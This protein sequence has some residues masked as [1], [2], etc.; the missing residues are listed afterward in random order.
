MTASYLFNPEELAVFTRYV[1]PDTLFAFDLDGTLAPIVDDYNAV[2][3]AEPVRDT[4]KR[5]AQL[6]KV[7]VITG[8]SRN[9]ALKILEFEPDLI[10]GNHGSEWPA[11]DGKRDWQQIALCVK[12]QEQLKNRLGDT[13][14]VEIEFKGESVSIHY[15][16][17]DDRE[18]AL[19]R[20]NDAIKIIEP[21]PR[22]IGGKFVVN[23][24]PKDATTKGDALVA[25]MDKFGL[26]RSVFLGDDVTDE[27]VFRLVGVDVLGI[28]IGKDYYTAA[29]YYLN[30]QS[31]L[32]GLLN[33]MVGTI[34]SLRAVAPPHNTNKHQS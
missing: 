10:I 30:D 6:A 22:R 3:I 14:G 7:V 29:K 25:A 15:R 32:L 11:Q 1:T 2:T 34:E 19:L 31:E 27:E 13:E 28:H 16:K 17:S 20:I 33:T 18:S 12:W 21:S 23:L 8:R 5:L 26:V 9:D 4:L 24:L